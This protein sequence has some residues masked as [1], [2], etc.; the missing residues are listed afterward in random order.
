MLLSFCLIFYE[1]WS[2]LTYKNVAYE[3]VCI[4]RFLMKENILKAT[5]TLNQKET[6][7]HP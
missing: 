2:D 7:S 1:F 5:K 6:C 4:S 3:K